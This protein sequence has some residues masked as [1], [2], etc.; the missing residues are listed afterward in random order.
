MESTCRPIEGHFKAAKRDICILVDPGSIP[1]RMLSVSTFI[2][3]GSYNLPAPPLC[4][5]YISKA[6]KFAD[7]SANNDGPSSASES[8]HMSDV[9]KKRFSHHS[10][11]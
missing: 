3:D 6:R 11:S 2:I 7:P 8:R 10:G 4:V 9:A 5:C 1:D